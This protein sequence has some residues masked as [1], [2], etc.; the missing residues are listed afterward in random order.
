LKPSVF[1]PSLLSRRL[2]IQVVAIAA[3][4]AGGLV[5]LSGAP[6]SLERRVWVA[7][8]RQ[9]SAEGIGELA[10]D[11]AL[12]AEAHRHSTRMAEAGFVSHSDPVR[13][14]LIP[15]LNADGI[16]WR[17]CAENI[18]LYEPGDEDPVGAVVKAWL[19]SPGHRKNLLNPLYTR[20]GV[21]MAAP[22]GSRVW[23][24]Q[25]FTRPPDSAA[26]RRTR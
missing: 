4:G 15:R 7:V 5:R 16:L 23:M 21:G 12:A 10:W 14:D 19:A 1:P 20:S 22:G 26:A 2:A 9:R 25:D 17:D 8:N 6:Q 3:A 11:D 24:T 13:G 18:I